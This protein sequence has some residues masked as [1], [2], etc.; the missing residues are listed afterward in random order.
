MI[1]GCP[2]G[3]LLPQCPFLT[4]CWKIAQ[5]RQT[6]G[7]FGWFLLWYFF[8]HLV[9]PAQHAGTLGLF[10][11]LADAPLTAVELHIPFRVAPWKDLFSRAGLWVHFPARDAQPLDSEKLP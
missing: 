9:G 6:G 4:P 7:F 8:Q 11:R 10:L 2:G 1:P 3:V 5:H